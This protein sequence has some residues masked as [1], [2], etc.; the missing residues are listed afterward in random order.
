M[1]W[2]PTAYELLQYIIIL[3]EIKIHYPL[4]IIEQNNMCGK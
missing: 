1:L 4:S 2:K 3:Y